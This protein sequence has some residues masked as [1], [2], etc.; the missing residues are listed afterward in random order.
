MDHHGTGTTSLTNND[1]LERLYRSSR[2]SLWSSPAPAQTDHQLAALHKYS[3]DVIKDQDT[4]FPIP[5]IDTIYQ[6]ISRTENSS[7]GQDGIPSRHGGSSDTP[8]QYSFI[9]SSLMHNKTQP[10]HGTA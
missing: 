3:T 4:S 1:D 2:E 10:K 5:D 9:N 7:P 8:S 6:V